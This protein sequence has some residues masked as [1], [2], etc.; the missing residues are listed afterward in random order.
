[1]YLCFVAV[2]QRNSPCGRSSWL[3]GSSSDDVAYEILDRFSVL[4]LRSC[5]QIGGCMYGR[6][7]SLRHP[8]LCICDPGIKA[9][10][11]DGL[12]SDWHESVIASAQLVAI[13]V[14]TS[15]ALDSRPGLVDPTRDGILLDA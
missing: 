5:C 11:R 3:E 10:A 7:E 6:W 4:S 15:F 1:M 8:T 14:I 13:A 2:S 12:Y 9:L